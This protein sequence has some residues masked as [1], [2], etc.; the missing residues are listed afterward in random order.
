MVLR[1]NIGGP[2]HLYMAAIPADLMVLGTVTRKSGEIGALVRCPSGAFA[3]LNG[4]V[5]QP[6]NKR[7]VVCA[8]VEARVEQIGN[9]ASSI[10]NAGGGMPPDV[11]AN[12]A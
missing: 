7:E 5:L 4:M 8:M 10:A 1:V 2:A 6:L 9:Q 12:S 3:Q 11:A